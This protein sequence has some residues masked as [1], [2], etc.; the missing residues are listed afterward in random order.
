M[1]MISISLDLLVMDVND[2]EIVW[3]CIDKLQFT[4][5]TI[6]VKLNNFFIDFDMDNLDDYEQDDF[7][8]SFLINLE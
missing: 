2:E 5:N 4:F 1:E 3:I 7:G 6:K 8:N